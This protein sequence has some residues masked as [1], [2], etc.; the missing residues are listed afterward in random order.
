MTGAQAG[1]LTDD[2]HGDATILAS[3]R[4]RCARRS[5]GHHPGR[6]RLPRRNRRGAITTLGRGGSDLTAIALGDALGADRVDIYTDVSGVMTADPRRVPTAHVIDRV[7][8][9]EMVELAGK[10]RR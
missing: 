6:H 5:S 7:S 1:I 9:A 2:T 4:E 8:L 10:A 3:I